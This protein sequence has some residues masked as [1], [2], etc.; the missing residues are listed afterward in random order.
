M[1]FLH[2]KVEAKRTLL[3]RGRDD[4]FARLRAVLWSA[5]TATGSHSLPTLRILPR[6]FEIKKDEQHRKG[7]TRLFG[8]DDRIRTC[9]F[10]VPN[11]APYQAGPHPEEYPLIIIQFKIKIKVF[12]LK[13]YFFKMLFSLLTLH[14]KIIM[15]K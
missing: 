13:C 5:L 4:R 6:P 1:T 2:K 15:I 10:Y 8:R 11:V 9:G 3:R 12:L 7:V 14:G